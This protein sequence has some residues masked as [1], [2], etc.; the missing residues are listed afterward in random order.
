M[1]PEKR[2]KALDNPLVPRVMRA[3]SR[4]NVWVYQ[5]T[6][7]RLGDKWRGG[8]AFPWGLPILLLITIGKKSGQRRTAPLLFIEEGGAFV[9]VASQG[10]MPNEPLWFT[11]L[12]ANPEVEVQMGARVEARRARVATPAEREHLWPLLVAHYA[13]FAAYQAWKDH[14]IPVVLLEPTLPG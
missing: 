10:G 5:K 12:V 9:V 2:P 1:N 3:L 6:G 7:G 13:D 14:T 8:S 4:A 11:N